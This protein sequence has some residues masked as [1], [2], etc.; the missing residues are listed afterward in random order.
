M[1]I[2][3]HHHVL[4]NDKKY[5]FNKLM[6]IFAI[7]L[8]SVLSLASAQTPISTQTWHEAT[9]GTVTVRTASEADRAY[10]SEVFAITERARR[11]LRAWGLTLAPLT[12]VIHPDIAS[13]QAATDMPWYIAAVANTHNRQLDMQRVRVLVERGSLTATLRHELFHLAQPAGLPRYIAEGLAMHFAAETPQA[14]PWQGRLEHLNTRLA[15]PASQRELQQ[16]MARAHAEVA[17]LLRQESAAT[18]LRRYSLPD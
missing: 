3:S 8:S 6:Y 12:V 11:D 18:L 1:F 5:F 2:P 15:Q 7:A 4:Q 10:L 13:Y 17:L 14:A 9:D 16:A